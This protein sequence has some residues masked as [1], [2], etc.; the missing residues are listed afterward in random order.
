M[1]EVGRSGIGARRETLLRGMGER[2]LLE[3][4]EPSPERPLDGQAEHEH[5]E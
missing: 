5:R 1:V 4:V 3:Q 2:G